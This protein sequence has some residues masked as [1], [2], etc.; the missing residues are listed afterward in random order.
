MKPIFHY[1]K[2]CMSTLTHEKYSKTSLH[3]RPP[4]FTQNYQ[5]PQTGPSIQSSFWSPPPI[6]N[7]HDHSFSID[8]TFLG[9]SSSRNII[10]WPLVCL[11]IHR[12]PPQVSLTQLIITY[13]TTIFCQGN[14][15]KKKKTNW[16]AIQG[17][18]HP[19]VYSKE[20]YIIWPALA[21]L[22]L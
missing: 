16:N 19:R 7:C 22:S 4:W 21:I 3:F 1:L 8:C 10:S 17:Y 20:V 5:D 2:Y 6:N 13:K 12:I 15:P 11:T 14:N 18:L 9:S